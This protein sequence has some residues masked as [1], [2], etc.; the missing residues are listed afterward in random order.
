MTK[1]TTSA[2]FADDDE[3]APASPWDL[4][5]PRKQTRAD[6]IRNLLPGS[7]VPES[8][9][10]AFD[11]VGAEGGGSGRVTAGG[12][13]R[14]LAAAKLAAD[15]QARIMG[16]LAPGGS[17]DV[18]LSRDEFNVLLALIGLAQ[19]GD[20]VSLDGIDERRR[21]ELRISSVRSPCRCYLLSAWR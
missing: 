15:D 11:A 14:T 10:A 12:V 4:P 16:I 18:A 20:S 9:I 8:Y 3:S 2:L 7:E 13:A 17:D 19:E 1:S 21:S 5:T 6:L